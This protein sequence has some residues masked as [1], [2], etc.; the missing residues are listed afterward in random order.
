MTQELPLFLMFA[1]TFK[2]E[3]LSTTGNIMCLLRARCLQ[4]TGAQLGNA[5]NGYEEEL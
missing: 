2:T 1:E 4:Q 5:A 3:A